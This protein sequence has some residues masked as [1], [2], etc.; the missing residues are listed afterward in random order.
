VLAARALAR[1]RHLAELRAAFVAGVSHELRTPVASILLLA[2]NLENGRVEGDAARA[3]YH[4]LI[5]REALRLRRLVDGVLDFSRLER[6][7]GV[8]IAR[9]DVDVRAWL[10]SV[11]EEARAWAAQH[12][13]EL[14]LELDGAPESARIDR[15]ALRRA[16]WNLLENAQRHSGSR[17]VVLR[18]RGGEGALVLEVED[19]G[20]GVPPAQRRAIF[21]PFAR[22]AEPGT[23]GTGLGLALVREIARAHAGSIE[24]ADGATGRGARFTVRIP[25]D[26]RNDD[27]GG[28]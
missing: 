15:E 4:G 11:A 2:E 1:E 27:E 24:V 26:G 19:A 22:F 8:E 16:L 21:E 23:P 7:R 10:A 14:V 18:A 13:V 9:E 5:R 20:R 17:S 12:D 28:R 3:R 6:G 25:A